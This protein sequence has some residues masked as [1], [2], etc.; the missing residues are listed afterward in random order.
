[1]GRSRPR[2]EPAL[3]KA[4]R[5]RLVSPHGNHDSPLS[6]LRN[7]VVCGVNDA[8]KDIVILENPSDVVDG[9]RF[10]PIAP[11][12][13]RQ[14]GAYVLNDDDARAEL[15]SE[16]DHLKNEPVLSLVLIV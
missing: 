4:L 15:L 13:Q 9:A 14:D 1:M 8:F 12:L 5:P 10:A 11:D 16:W 6:D 7:A 2:K 3:L